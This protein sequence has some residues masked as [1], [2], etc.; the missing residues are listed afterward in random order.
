[1]SNHLYDRRRQ[2]LIAGE[3]LGP[4]VLDIGYAQLPNPNLAGHAVTGLDLIAPDTIP[5]GYAAV[6]QGDATSVTSLFAKGAF[7]SI[8]FGEVIEHLERPYD[9]LRS[10]RHVLRPRGQIVFS[11]P[12]P[13][14]FPVAL[15][16]LLQSRRFFYTEDHT[17][18]FLPRWV[19]RM[20]SRTGFKL[21][22]QLPVGLWLPFPAV[23]P[24][25]VWLSYQ[26]VYAAEAVDPKD[27]D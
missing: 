20:L 4:R 18:Y 2:Q 6:V 12:N 22:R 15:F 11:T 25:P 26:V 17:F 3:V 16:E 27:G 5:S 1:M 10:L 8:V 23:L 13:G 7:D 19:S 21:T 9:F 24:A 14:S